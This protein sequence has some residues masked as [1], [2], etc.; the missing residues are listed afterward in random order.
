MAGANDGV[1][2]RL[3]ALSAGDRQAAET[4]IPILYVELRR[5]A[6]SLLSRL[7]PGQTLQATALVHEAYVK[8]VGERDPGWQGRAHF[9]GAAARAMREILVDQARRKGAEKR[10][11]DWQRVTLNEQRVGGDSR[12]IDVLALHFALERLEQEDPRKGQIVILRYFAG[13]TVD[14][15]ATLMN[16]SRATV[17]RDWRFAKVWLQSQIAGGGGDES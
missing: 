13:L 6:S 16:L 2:R 1:T 8:L 15:I 9:F 3:D 17:E 10:G 12:R 5:L 7:K 14:E 11:A 4:L